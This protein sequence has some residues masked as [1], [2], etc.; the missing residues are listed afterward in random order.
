MHEM[1][2]FKDVPVIIKDRYGRKYL[3]DV[4]IF[5]FN[6]ITNQ[7]MTID[8]KRGWAYAYRNAMRYRRN[9]KKK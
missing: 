4:P 2:I 1:T 3:A 9:K 8:N 7:I 6:T 5:V